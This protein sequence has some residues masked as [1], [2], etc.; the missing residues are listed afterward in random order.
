MPLRSQGRFPWGSD[1]QA[2]VKAMKQIGWNVKA[3]QPL[4]PVPGR[5][6]MLATPSGRRSPRADH[7]YHA[8]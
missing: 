4:Q 2:L 3:L 7:Q 6:S 5:G 8:W 1:R